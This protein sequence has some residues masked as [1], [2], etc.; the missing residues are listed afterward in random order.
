MLV[1]RNSQLLNIKL[2]GTHR[3]W[4][5]AVLLLTV[6][7]TFEPKTMSLVGYPKIIPYTK[8]EHFGIIRFGVMVRTLVWKMHFLTMRPWPWP[9]NPKTVPLLEYLKVIP[10]TKFEHFWI[11][12]FWLMLRTNRQTDR[13]TNK[14]TNWLENPTHADRLSRRV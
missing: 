3:V 6:T 10:Y 14:Q 13:Q 11:V 1:T 8:F 12:R 4:T 7:L 5:H 2:E 9:L